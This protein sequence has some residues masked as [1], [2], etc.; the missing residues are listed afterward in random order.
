[1]SFVSVFRVGVLA[2]A[3]M[4]TA[5]AAQAT[6]LTEASVPGGAFGGAWN[7]LT[8]VGAGYEALSGSGNQNQYDNFLFTDLRAGRQ[9]LTFDFTAPA[10]YDHS[11]SAGAAILTSVTPF[12]WGWDGA[13]AKTVQVDYY[14]PT[15]SFTL[16]LGDDFRGGSL[17]LALNFTHGA[18][19]AYRIGVPGNAPA[20]PQTPSPAPV[21]LPAGFVLLGSGI[22]ALGALGA[23]RRRT[24]VTT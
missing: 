10:G 2:A 11:Y 9:T 13:Y 24:A 14:K 18:N 1:M 15:Q 8:T 16:D 23:R 3:A 6:T 21:P 4:M 20:M 19:L 5:V 17:Y 12:R 22:A 7:S